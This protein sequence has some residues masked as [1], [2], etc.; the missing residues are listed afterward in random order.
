[1]AGDLSTWIE[2]WAAFAPDK[3]A[4]D[5]DGE[6]LSYAALAGRIGA[7][8]ASLDAAPGDRIAYLGQNSPQ[9]IELVF[10]CARLGAIAVPLNWRLTVDE[11]RYVLQNS[12]AG[13]LIH[14]P[15]FAEAAS[16]AD[17]ATIETGSWDSAALPPSRGG[18]DNSVL[19][20]YTSGTTGRPK[21]AVLDQRALSCNALNSTAMH[22]LTSADRV[23]T[24]IPLFHVGGLNIQTLPALHAGA[25]VFLHRAF[26][27]EATFAAIARDR[28]TLAVLVPA[29][30][31]AMQAHPAWG[32]CDLSCLRMVT[33]G[34][35]IVPHGLIEAFHARGVPVVQVYGCTET[36]PI[37]TYLRA[38]QA[39]GHV[40]SVGLAA[41]HSEVRIVDEDGSVVAA[42]E[43]GEIW[44]RGDNVMREY[45]HDPEASA[46]AFSDGWFRTGDI[47]ERGEDGFLSVVD[48]KRDMIISG[49]ENVYPAEIERVLA[50][51]P[52][53]AEVAVVGREDARWG[54]VAVAVVVRGDP[55]LDADGVLALLDGHLAR[56]KHPHD[57][58]FVDA[59]PRNAMGK[60]EK[61][62][63]REMV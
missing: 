16:T 30:M 20:V 62:V 33:T 26:D 42:G 58:I 28:P 60:V 9:L 43:R 13:A 8:A 21:G 11:H 1:M 41:L 2:H 18:P 35:T 23:L 38:D 6:R 3:T 29:Q 19:I 22:D 63:L 12:G 10:A 37:A 61:P 39:Y 46:A 4:I 54:E 31:Q 49:S 52:A 32:H 40:G 15:D 7:L 59:L 27:V 36:A 47:A 14:E 25:T 51:A 45:W 57:V 17:I 5:C 55:A 48:R 34:S 56:Y 50:D 44:V 24:T 53:I